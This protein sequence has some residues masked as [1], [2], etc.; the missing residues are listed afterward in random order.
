[1]GIRLGI[2]HL[3]VRDFSGF[4]AYWQQPGVDKAL[5]WSQMKTGIALTYF[6]MK[7]WVDGDGI[8][9]DKLSGRLE[10]ALA[11]DALYFS[12]EMCNELSQLRVIVYI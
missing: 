5:V 12:Q 10:I 7:G 3:N 8:L 4:I 6:M 2:V 11:L 1:M 9:L